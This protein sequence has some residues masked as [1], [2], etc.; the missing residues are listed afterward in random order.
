MA[1]AIIEVK[2]FN[3]FL[4]KKTV[5]NG[6]DVLWNGSFGIPKSIGGYP[7]TLANEEADSWVIEESRIR[8]GYNNTSVDFGAKAYIV[9]EEPQGTRRFNAIIYSGIFNSRTGINK[10]NVFSVAEDITKAADPANGSIQKLYAEDTNLNVFQ[11]LKVSRALIDKDAI[12]A[13]E[14]GG[15]VTASN[16]VIGVIQPYAGKFGISKNPESF[17]SYGFRKYFSDVNNNSILRLSKDG[18]TEIS[19]YGMK[20][21]FR[22]ELNAV[23]TNQLSGNIF[24]AYDIYGKDYVISMQNGENFKTLNFDEKPSGWVSF[25]SY[26]PDQAFSLRNN[27]YTVKSIG[28]TASVNGAVTASPNVIIDGVQNF[29]EQYSTVELLVQGIPNY[30]AVPLGTTVVSFNSTTG[31]LVLSG[32][33]TLANNDFLTFGGVAKLWQH[34]DTSVNRGSFYGQ[35]NKTSITFVFNPNPTNSKT[36]NT[37]AYE[38]SN[39]WQVDQYTS[40]PTGTQFVEAWQNSTDLASSIKSY[41]E[42]EYIIT[43]GSG[44]TTSASISNIVSLNLANVTGMIRSGDIVSGLGVQLGTTVVSYNAASGLLTVSASLSVALGALLSFSGSVVRADYLSVFGTL[45]PPNQKNYTGFVLKENKY[46]ANLLNNSIAAPGEIIFGSAI[47]GIKGFYSTVKL[48]TDST[49]DLGGEKT[50]FSTE[51]VYTMNNGY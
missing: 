51:S 21:F 27:F 33:V 29:I 3:T 37:I 8:G 45:N 34:Y 22:D 24:G 19:N 44:L 15:T 20:D 41:T 9:E 46:V 25:F 11:E 42:G 1:G 16:L 50:L 28:G 38:G 17:A 18:L 4:L 7:A 6:K 48:S 12:Y 36:F 39:G 10:T 30:T 31:A 14:G 23:T 47:S 26:A 5:N 43:E 40:D 13:A 2:Y 35:D 32:N 49:T